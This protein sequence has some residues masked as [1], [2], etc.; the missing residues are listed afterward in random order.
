MP[1]IVIAN[2]HLE[3][4]I[5]K[6]YSLPRKTWTLS[7]Y[8][9]FIMRKKKKAGRLY[10]PTFR[11]RSPATKM[12]LSRGFTSETGGASLPFLC[13]L[14][15]IIASKCFSLPYPEVTAGRDFRFLSDQKLG[16]VAKLHVASVLDNG[17]SV[18]TTLRG[19]F[20]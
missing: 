20:T 19:S 12:A 13:S 14:R 3:A 17:R 6:D 8:L 1:C 5:N 18:P 11:F 16:L 10:F 9:A 2:W 4:N 15:E 7:K